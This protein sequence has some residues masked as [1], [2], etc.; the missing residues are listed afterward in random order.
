MRVG[1]PCMCAAVLRRKQA[2][3]V[4]VLVACVFGRAGTL[5][6]HAEGLLEVLLE[7]EADILTQRERAA[8]SEGRAARSEWRDAVAWAG[9]RAWRLW[10]AALRQRAPRDR[11]AQVWTILYLVD[12]V[13]RC[14]D[15]E[16]RGANRGR[17]WRIVSGMGVLI[18][19][20][21]GLHTQGRDS[22]IE[23][24][25]EN[26]S[27]RISDRVREARYVRFSADSPEAVSQ[28]VRCAARR[29]RGEYG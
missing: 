16:T 26:H 20:R 15:S 25:R 5:T 1:V 22:A 24:V 7:R 13:D 18:G 8:P 2:V 10:H 6:G 11:A 28:L 12:T 17:P 19:R 23:E 27:C 9:S 14:I 21:A 4:G 29:A 3:W